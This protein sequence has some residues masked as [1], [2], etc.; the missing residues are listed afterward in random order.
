MAMGIV[1]YARSIPAWKVAKTLS[2]A[3]VKS[4]HC[5]SKSQGASVA[6]G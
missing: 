4:H 5:S 1:G 6:A 3:S 2:M